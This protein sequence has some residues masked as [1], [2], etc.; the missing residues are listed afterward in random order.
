MADRRIVQPLA[1]RQLAVGLGDGQQVTDAVGLGGARGV[2][3]DRAGTQVGDVALALLRLDQRAV[4][5]FLQAFARN[6]PGASS[7]GN[8]VSTRV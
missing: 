4:A 8:V 2:L 6:L 3:F 5:G 7:V 1:G